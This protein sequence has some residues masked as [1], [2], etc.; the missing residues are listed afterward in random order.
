MLHNVIFPQLKYYHVIKRK[1]AATEAFSTTCAVH[2][3]D[4]EG[5]DLPSVQS[6][7]STGPVFNLQ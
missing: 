2:L 1:V 7:S 6:T 3:E 5:Q 4:R